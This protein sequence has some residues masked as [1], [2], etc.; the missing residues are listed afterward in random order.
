M[1]KKIVLL[2]CSLLFVESIAWA[3]QEV[4]VKLDR[5]GHEIQTVDLGYATVTFHF[6][7]VYNNRAQVKVLVENL[8]P[9]Q[10]I[11]LFNGTQDEKMLKKRRPKILFEKTYGGEKGHRFVSG[12]RDI[13]NIFEQIKPAE[14]VNL[15]VFDGSV[16]ETTD[17]LI[18]FY[19]AK[20]VPKRFL[21][22]AKYRILRED[23][24]KF[25]L[26][27]DGWSEL[28]PTYVSVKRTISDL[29]ASLKNVKFCGN[30]MHK[31]SLAEQQSP[32]QAVKDSM[33]GVIDSIFR[34]NP[35]MSQDLPHQAYTRLKSEVEAVNLDEY[36][37]DCGK[38]KRVHRCGYCSLS[39]E[40]IYHR[41][42]DTYQ[43]LHTGRISKDEAV[44]TA[45]ALHNCYHQNRRRGRDSFYGGKINDYYERIINF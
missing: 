9:S 42:D 28:D 4:L 20:Y 14:T 39:T 21:R 7:T 34:S 33:I 18:P 36:V 44:K 25:I 22:S 45:R 26:E 38:H 43:R 31:P 37:S 12:C 8:T 17:L 11:L 29:K 35:W 41:L 10:T 5:Q 27:I 16:T 40:Q 32:Y 3:D 30:K 24:I 1:I 15:F 13:R 6:E 2:L 19:I 23:N